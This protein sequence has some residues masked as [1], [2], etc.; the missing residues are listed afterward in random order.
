MVTGFL[1]DF[2]F[3]FSSSSTE[4]LSHWLL[5]AHGGGVAVFQLPRRLCGDSE[6]PLTR[7]PLPGLSCLPDSLALLFEISN[8]HNPEGG[9]V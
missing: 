1:W 3:F 8:P 2:F 7:N 6:G 5:G 9:L 4:N